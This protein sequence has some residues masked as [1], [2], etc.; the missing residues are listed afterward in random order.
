MRSKLGGRIVRLNL[1]G[2][3]VTYDG[4]ALLWKSKY[5]GSV[6]DDETVYDQFYNLQA[7]VVM[8]EIGHTPA[9]QQYKDILQSR[10]KKIFPLP[11]RKEFEITN[12][13][14]AGDSSQEEAMGF[15]KVILFDHGKKLE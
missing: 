6:R 12:L 7:S 4:I 1:M 15:K 8:I 9:L 3:S 2:T 14:Y 11:L 13:S 10:E 5:L